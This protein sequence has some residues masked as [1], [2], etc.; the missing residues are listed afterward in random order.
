MLCCSASGLVALQL[1]DCC[2]RCGVFCLHPLPACVRTRART[3]GSG[4]WRPWTTP[5]TASASCA[6]S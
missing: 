2:A 3:A 5:M 6:A 1:H 4:G